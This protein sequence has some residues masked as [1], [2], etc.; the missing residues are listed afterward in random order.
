MTSF[1]KVRVLWLQSL[2]PWK[3]I[4]AKVTCFPWCLDSEG[5]TVYQR[6]RDP[7]VF[8]WSVMPNF[9]PS[10]GQR[11]CMAPCLVS[12]EHYFPGRFLQKFGSVL[13]FLKLVLSHDEIKGETPSGEV[14]RI[15]TGSLL[16][17]AGKKLWWVLGSERR[18]PMC[19]D[20]SVVELDLCMCLPGLA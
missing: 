7:V 10:G 3:F 19:Q 6:H 1:L 17:P 9:T 2:L 13:F 4:K 18:T 16:Q 20:E 5:I 8:L 12:G 11:P 14:W 15:F